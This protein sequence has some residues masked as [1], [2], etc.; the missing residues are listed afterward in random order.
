MGSR[1]TWINLTTL[2]FNSDHEPDFVHDMNKL[3]LPF[4]NDTFDEIHAYE[5]LEHVGKQGDYIFFF[6]QFSDLYRILKPNGL[7]VAMSPSI[8]RY[9][10]IIIINKKS[11]IN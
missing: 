5:V 10:K 1:T 4:D 7:L 6:A 3:P 2:D 8:H 9:F 11:M